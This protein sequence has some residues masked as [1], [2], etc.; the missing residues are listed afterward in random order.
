MEGQQTTIKSVT[1]VIGV[2]KKAKLQH[3]EGFRLSVKAGSFPRDVELEC[4]R[5]DQVNLRYAQN[6]FTLTST[7]ISTKI[8][9]V[10]VQIDYTPDKSV[11]KKATVPFVELKEA[12]QTFL[13]KGKL[14]EKALRRN[15]EYYVV[16]EC[17]PFRKNFSV[18]VGAGV[19][20]FPGKINQVF[21]PVQ[22]QFKI[23][24]GNMEEDATGN[25]R[26]RDQHHA[27]CSGPNPQDIHPACYPASWAALCNCYCMTPAHPRRQ[28]EVGT[29]TEPNPPPDESGDAFS[30]WGMGGNT[31]GATPQA[32]RVEDWRADPANP[33]PVNV[34]METVNFAATA[35]ATALAARAEL[36]KSTLLREVGGYI[37]PFGSIASARPVRMAHNGHAWLIVG[38]S[39]DG[40]WDHALAKNAWSFSNFCSWSDAPW[41]SN[42][43]EYRISYPEAGNTLRPEDKRLGCI[44][45]EGSGDKMPRIRFW[46]AYTHSGVASKVINWVPHTR[47]D[48]G[49]IWTYEAEPLDCLGY[50]ES[51]METDLGHIIPR[52]T[53]DRGSCDFC[54]DTA[55]GCSRCRTRLIL[56]FWVHNTTLDELV[57]YKLDLYFFN[58]HQRWVSL[59]PQPIPESRGKTT[60]G[61]LYAGFGGSRWTDYNLSGPLPGS[62]FSIQATHDPNPGEPRPEPWNSQGFAWYIDFHR[63]QMPV[64]GLYGI[65]L[66]LSCSERS[67]E[68]VCVEQDRKQLWFQVA[69]PAPY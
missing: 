54:G 56:P 68:P 58:Q 24:E 32:C 46:D 42:G 29:P 11:A 53:Q 13:F 35:G 30:T 7:E 9:K 64:N 43:R 62:R 3:P 6:R 31:P 23:H 66:V 5:Q 60:A 55:D 12:D 17:E 15:K 14:I 16:A 47:T 50:P 48:A 40:Y 49:Y 22:H 39:K 52:P 38:V 65:R 63:E 61:D 10:F 26:R 45:F 36:I 41:N 2:K 37:P 69:D 59:L 28:W 8:S 44:N 4:T 19:F 25:S 67:G 18:E 21:H 27:P 33:T 1:R 34:T 51:G 57:T 20:F